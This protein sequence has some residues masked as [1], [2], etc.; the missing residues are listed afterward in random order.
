MAANSE[1]ASTEFYR[2]TLKIL[3]ESGFPYLVGGAF[4]L[5]HYTDIQRDSK[6]IDLF[7][8]PDDYPRLLEVLSHHGYDTETTNEVWLAKACKGSYFIDIIFSSRNKICLVD[9]RWFR[10]SVQGR[11]WDVEV[12]FISAEDLLWGKLYIQH[13]ERFDG[14]DINHLL[15]QHGH[16]MDWKQLL[17]LTGNHWPLLL[18]QI[19]NFSFVYPGTTNRIPGWVW[20]ELLSRASGLA[21]ENKSDKKVCC[22]PLLDHQQYQVDIEE[23]DFEVPTN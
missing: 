23:W 18:S 13:R 2:N 3:N 8:K 1:Q 7:C 9:D 10:H 6:D 20:Q 22:G 4:A 12:A 19:I 5:R 14:A 15:L 21:K 16:K 17:D 11:L